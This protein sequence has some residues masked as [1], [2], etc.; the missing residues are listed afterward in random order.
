MAL[1]LPLQFLIAM[2]AH[3]I[4]ERMARRIEYLLEENRVLR[5]VFTETTGRKRLP[6][7]DDQRRRLAVRGKPL[8]PEER[9]SC[10]QIVRPDTILAWFRQLVAR[11]YDS[12]RL[13]RNPGRPRKS[14][15]IRVLVIRLA[16]EN[17]TW[18]YTKIR[19]ALRGLRVDIGRTTVASILTEAGI[20]PAPERSRKRTWKQFLRIHWE[21][22]HA[23]DFFA[24][25]TL[26]VFGTIRV[27]VFFVMELQSRAVHIAG[28][29]INPDSAWLMQVTRNLLDPDEG[30]LRT[31][32]HLIHDRDPLFTKAWTALLKSSCVK[33][34]PIPAS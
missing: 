6:L 26:G 1:P 21:T 19:D 34:V 31:A 27:M 23:C 20:E 4:N 5:E 25:E 33:S 28:I 18:G 30:F 9:E 11:R 8:T 14:D 24:V 22:L 17:L 3:A 7:T 32:T 13:R 12:S 29:R 10:C 16:R 15:D 2:V